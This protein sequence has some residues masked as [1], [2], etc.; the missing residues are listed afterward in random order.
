MLPL[1][2]TTRPSLA[3]YFRIKRHAGHK[4]AV[5]RSAIKSSKLPSISCE[6]GSTTEHTEPK[7][8]L[9]CRNPPILQSCRREAGDVPRAL[10]WRTP[11]REYPHEAAS[12]VLP[13]DGEIR[14]A[15]WRH[16]GDTPKVVTQE[17]ID[18]VEG[19]VRRSL[20]LLRASIARA[21]KE[22]VKV[23]EVSLRRI[24]EHGKSST[25]KVATAPKDEPKPAAPSDATKAV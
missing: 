16:P 20:M 14:L 17:S 12:F 19:R 5:V 13:T 22:G 15:R 7:R 21:R 11:P 25:S 18:V 10:G 8:P 4:K 2:R 23:H 1:G 6:T 3:R 24:L 9:P